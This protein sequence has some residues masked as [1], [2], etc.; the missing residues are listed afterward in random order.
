MVHFLPWFLLD[1]DPHE[2]QAE[3]TQVLLLQGVFSFGL[4]SLRAP[5]LLFQ[6][7]TADGFITDGFF[8]EARAPRLGCLLG[9]QTVDERPALRCDSS[10]PEVISSPSRRRGFEPI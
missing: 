3:P 10:V 7:H 1:W 8:A 6:I 5:T 9:D 4:S 2:F